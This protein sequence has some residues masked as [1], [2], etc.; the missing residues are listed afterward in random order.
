M[1]SEPKL[2]DPTEAALSA[3]EEALSIDASREGAAKPADVPEP[4]LPDVGDATLVPERAAAP[5]IEESAPPAAPREAAPTPPRPSPAIVSPDRAAVA[6][7]DRRNVGILLQALQ[8][9]PSRRAYFFATLASLV[10]LGAIA[11]FVVTR[12]EGGYEAFLSNLTPLQMLV[13]VVALM[14]PVILF[15]IAAMLAVRSQEMKLLARAVG[16]VAVRL[17]EPEAYSADAMVS[18]SQAVRR[19]VAAV[20]DG[21]ER[22]LAR[23]GELE[24][25]VRSEIAT[26]ERAYSDNEIRT[27]SSTSSSRNASRSS[28]TPSACDRRSQARTRASP[29]SS[30]PRPGGSLTPRPLPESGSPPP[31]T[32]AAT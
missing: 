5:A 25:L 7:D 10:W 24:T 12:I 26:L 23:A 14:G 9:R 2:K 3:I 30:T 19:E 22:A 31:S 8:R 11:A 16:E 27:R 13:G 29:P 6:N 1:A 21:V 17:A 15:Y 28:P 20:G 18:V 32:S 4:R